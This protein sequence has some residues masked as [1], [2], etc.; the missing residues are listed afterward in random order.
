MR[1]VAFRKPQTSMSL[2]P[3][4]AVLICTMGAL[5]ALLILVVHQAR[6][7]A[8]SVLDQRRQADASAQA[9]GH[10]PAQEV[11]DLQWQRDIL[12]QQRRKLSQTL[13]DGRREL[14]HLE[15]HVRRLESQWKR[16]A[17]EAAETKRSQQ[18]DLQQASTARDELAALQAEIARQRQ[19][20]D[21][22]RE[23]HVQRARSFAIVPYQ[24]GHGTRRRPIYIECRES[25]I[26]IQPEGIAFSPQD[27]TGPLGPGNPL[28][29]ALRAIREH[30]RRLEG[31]A[32]QGEPY[33]LLVVRPD[34]AVAYSMARAAMSGW[35]DEFGYELVEAD[36]ELT[37]PPGD[38][39]LK[40]LLQ[41]AIRTARDRQAVLAAAMPSRF[42][43]PS[44]ATF[45]A[46]A[47]EAWGTMTGDSPAGA[48]RG[49]SAFGSGDGRDAATGYGGGG[50]S[51]STA[52]GARDG[53]S[54]IARAAPRATGLAKTPSAG[55]Q[56]SASAS[57]TAG[58]PTATAGGQTAPSG[59]PG[60]APGAPG[61]APRALAATK[62]AD[63]ALPKDTGSATGITRPITVLCH[64]DRLVI[65]PDRRDTHDPQVIH[66]DGATRDAMEPFVSAIWAHMERW[67]MA[68]AGGYWKPTLK[69]TVYPGA[70]TRFWELQA[71]M[72]GSGID[73]ERR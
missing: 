23:Q 25:G 53:D 73:V 56:P 17:A 54:S 42:D 66:L 20:L 8:S 13:G 22:L 46:T 58:A 45:A 49:A 3:F 36:I 40:Q 12:E 67:G 19:Q 29:A 41:G 4:L 50:R 37:Y 9:G 52:D 26:V 55:V 61:A 34:G 35:E 47:D 65:M 39:S 5:I 11:E 24:G 30:W 1:R 16:L 71:L 18:G 28:D 32:G 38:P 69:I 68:V 43:A 60:A 57:A 14:A 10:D 62:G 59:S 64:P 21:R 70:E 27:F 48:A 72:A 33:P 51:R 7:Q 63:W 6:A 2:F 31:D 44:P 15:E